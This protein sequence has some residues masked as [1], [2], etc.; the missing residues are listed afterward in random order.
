MFSPLSHVSA[1]DYYYIPP[2]RTIRGSLAYVPGFQLLVLFGEV[3]ANG[4][5]V[6]QN[7]LNNFT[8]EVCNWQSHSG[9][10]A[11]SGYDTGIFI[12]DSV[13]TYTVT[14][15]A[16]YAVPIN[17]TVHVKIFSA[18]DQVDDGPIQIVA[19]H[20][21]LTFQIFTE[22]SPFSPEA[23]ADVLDQRQANRDQAII[24]SYT[25]IGAKIDAVDD[26]LDQVFTVIFSLIAA[27]AV[28]AVIVARRYIAI[29]GLGGGG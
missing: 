26:R 19:T 13:N 24:N 15:A 29:P 17:Q 4:V 10:C 12:T 20:I 22:K 28:I 11:V 1:V 6:A 18:G 25:S 7:R 3:S 21:Q 8:E 2:V 27:I 9:T 5:Q 23:L 14:F 16:D